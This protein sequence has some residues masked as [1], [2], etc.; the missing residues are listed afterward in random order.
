LFLAVSSPSL[1]VI[2]S[3]DTE[4]LSEGKIKL[5]REQT[6]IEIFEIGTGNLALSLDMRMPI[7]DF[8]W[9][10]CGRYLSACAVGATSSTRLSVMPPSV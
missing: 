4:R 6:K 8:A 7:K 2:V 1:P 10:H 9:S 5:A 3:Q